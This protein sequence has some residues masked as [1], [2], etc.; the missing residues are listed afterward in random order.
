MSLIADELK[1]HTFSSEVQFDRN[2]WFLVRVICNTPDN[3][4]FASTA[5]FYVEVGHKKKLI[6]S[7]SAKF[8]LDWVN[9]RAETLVIKNTQHNSE[10]AKYLT[11]AQQYWKNVFDN[12][13]DK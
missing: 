4:R 1:D 9:E 8:F 12:A 2:G 6:S 3:F 10:V 5:P 13:T 7:A 11:A